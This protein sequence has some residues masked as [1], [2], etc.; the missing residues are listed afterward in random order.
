[1]HTF[2]R[3]LITEWRRLKLP[4]ADAVCVLAVSGGADSCALM[5]AVS[6]L[7]R[8]KKLEIDVI[9][10]HYDHGLR[11]RSSDGDRK[12][13]AKLAGDLA[14]KFVTEKGELPQSGNLEQNARR[15]RYDFLERAAA[16][17]NAFAVMTAH[18]L[19]DQAETFLLNLIRGAGI[20][21]LSAMPVCRSISEKNTESQLIRPLLSW[22]K[23]EDTEQYCHYRKI[24]YRKDPMNNDLAFRRVMMRKKVLPL[25]RT[26]NPKI[27]ETLATT[28]QIISAEAKKNDTDANFDGKSLA[29]ASLINLD[30][31]TAM[32][33]VRR[34]LSDVLKTT[35]GI[36]SAHIRSVA[37]LA[38][39]RKSGRFAELPKGV[40]IVKKDGMLSVVIKQG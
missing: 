6:E 21:G 22:A 15:A 19:N 38:T 34:W 23:R 28:S 36:S 17:N 37:S 14:L 8:R 40:R 5:L 7:I 32:A 26:L 16:V 31:E 25:L 13:T 9:I 20:D 10:A 39:S 11:G 24:N 30:E 27:I 1:M 3:H 33:E 35:R 2:E 29:I 12:F 18:T 4:T